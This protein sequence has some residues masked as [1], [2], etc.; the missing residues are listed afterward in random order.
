[1]GITIGIGAI[2]SGI[3]GLLGGL[4]YSFAA[5]SYQRYVRKRKLRI[6]LHAEMQ[7]IKT[8]LDTFTE[9]YI[10]TGGDKS[11]YRALYE[12]KVY[13]ENLGELDVL[14]DNEIGAVTA[15]FD[16]LFELKV[17]L[18]SMTEIMEEL[19]EEGDRAAVL[20]KKRES[21]E[22]MVDK[23]QKILER[24]SK[25]IRLAMR[26]ERGKLLNWSTVYEL[27]HARYQGTQSVNDLEELAEGEDEIS[28][29]TP[30]PISR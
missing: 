3:L 22:D 27:I 23:S 28:K 6:Q 12:P 18:D 20:E 9:G 13:Q 1:M 16:H 8:L 5:P 2:I 11:T 24:G 15:A 10:E 19:E 29:D 17:W 26:D 25:A 7:L 4:S 30:P 21:I 14:T